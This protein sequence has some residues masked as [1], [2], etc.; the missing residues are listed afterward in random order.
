VPAHRRRP[1]R[2]IGLAIVLA[3][4]VVLQGLTLEAPP[5]AAASAPACPPNDDNPALGS[6]R[7]CVA[8]LLRSKIPRHPW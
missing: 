4:L 2:R 3:T 5:A 7:R 6:S 1:R 8:E